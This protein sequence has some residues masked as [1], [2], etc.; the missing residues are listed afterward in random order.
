MIP[1]DAI[2]FDLDG[3]LVDSRRDLAHSVQHLQRTYGSR[4]STS[5]EVGTYIGDG[6][7][8]LVQRSLPQLPEARLESAVG[9]F[10]QYYRE[11][12]LD[13]TRPYKSV[14]STLKHFRDKKMAVVTN[15]PVRISGFILDQLCLSEYFALVIGGDSL[16]NKKPHPE[17]ILNALKSMRV[18]NR[19]R[20]VVV[21]DSPNDIL[22]GRAA[23]TYTCGVLSNIGDPEKLRNSKP[24]YV[25]RNLEELI[26]IFN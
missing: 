22:A 4:V 2:L 8:K 5:K 1:V 20:V 21:G 10:K 13:H 26:R 19:R 15:K 9:K 12:C 18:I 16:P 11:H 3:T 24:D 25:V 7:V 6:V 14:S 23:G 17:P